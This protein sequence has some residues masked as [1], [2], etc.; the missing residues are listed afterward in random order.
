MRAVG[1]SLIGVETGKQIKID[2][3]LER[4]STVS[5]KLHFEYT[6][7]L[8]PSIVA[9]FGLSHSDEAGQHNEAKF[10]DCLEY[11]ECDGSEA[12]SLSDTQEI[13][14]DALEEFEDL[15]VPDWFECEDAPAATSSRF[16]SH[17]PRAPSASSRETAGNLELLA[18]YNA[19]CARCALSSVTH[20]A[21]VPQLYACLFVQA[22]RCCPASR[23]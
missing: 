7:S 16:P 19:M 4:K 10:Y 22:A 12:A 14:Y 6:A 17:P 9:S 13:W 15:E 23:L 20:V 1:S 2:C 5:R 8:K 3:A 11:Q 21:E 18:D